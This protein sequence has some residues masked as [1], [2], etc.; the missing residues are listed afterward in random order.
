MKCI[1]ID[2]NRDSLYAHNEK[3]FL[4]VEYSTGFRNKF[5][6]KNEKGDTVYKCKL[7]P[8]ITETHKI[9]DA[10]GKTIIKF[11]LDMITG[12]NHFNL[13]VNSKNNNYKNE[14]Y[15]YKNDY[16]NIN[17]LLCDETFDTRKYQIEYF[18]KASGY[19]NVIQ[20][21]DRSYYRK[22]FGIV[23]DYEI[24]NGNQD[25]NA[26]LICEADQSYKSKTKSSIF[27]QSG[28]EPLYMVVLHL[29]VYLF[30]SYKYNRKWINM[31]I[32]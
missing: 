29:C 12:L 18:N 14:E 24:Y 5:N 21:I 31:Y 6:I 32:F 30:H 17:V 2:S 15:F 3:T 20:L 1:A 10:K 13:Y 4:N 26:P 9:T 25:L 23:Y 11:S 19:T 16:M 28:V 8:F 27:I 22:N 7:N